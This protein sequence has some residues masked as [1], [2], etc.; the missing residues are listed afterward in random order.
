MTS[1]PSP[2]P[3]TPLAQALALWL[4]DARCV[5][6]RPCAPAEAIGRV[7]AEDVR[8]PRTVPERPRARRPGFAVA[9]ADTVGA[10]P[11]APA[12]C[13]APPPFVA[14]GDPLPEGCDAVLPA[15]ALTDGPIPEIQAEVAPGTDVRRAGAE[16]RAGE[17]VIP[18]GRRLRACD[19]AALAALGVATVPV[20]TPRVRLEGLP[21]LAGLVAALG[22]EVVLEDADLVLATT[23]GDV[24][25]LVDGLALRP[26]ETTRL[27]RTA[28]GVPVAIL[29]ALDSDALG[30]ALALLP[31]ALAALAGAEP[32]PPRPARLATPLTSSVGLAEV[33]LLARDGDACA[34]LAVG[35][36]T[37]ATFAR[38]DAFTLL[39]PESEGH[40]AGESIAVWML[41]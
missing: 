4:G 32:P 3:L 15:D 34:S 6:P 25:I 38:A 11:Y 12:P 7:L 27:A 1:V 41:P 40:A 10:S 30:A 5:A 31:P 20:C 19:A 17:V 28:D 18:A 36:L 39:A 26:G 22:G 2:R 35:D 23:S 37:L 24:E 13:L 33:A 8:T 16:A 9:A 14:A 29:P 21:A